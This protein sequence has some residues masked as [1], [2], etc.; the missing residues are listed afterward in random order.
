MVYCC[1]LPAKEIATMSKIDRDFPDA[2]PLAWPAGWPITPRERR[3][4]AKFGTQTREYSQTKDEKT[5][6]PVSSWMR[7]KRITTAQAR[8]RLLDELEMLRAT[9]VVL[10]TNVRT[11]ARGEL[12]AGARE[13]DHPGAA[14]YFRLK[15]EPRVLACDRWDRLADNLAA[16]AAHVDATRGI[17][18]WGVGTLDQVYTGYRALSAVGERA[19]WW[20]VM[21]FKNPPTV[22]ELETKYLELMKKH[23]PDRGGNA[24]QAAE[25]N[26]AYV[27][28]R[29]EMGL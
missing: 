7:K 9:D 14:V 2:Y 17:G 8:D 16:L 29:K 28:G 6:R 10:S 25:V 15:G 21:G 27:E 26:A 11:T 18:R 4:S 3:Q 1:P 22:G 20:Q 5:G 13:P 23:H 24:N 12:H 19:K